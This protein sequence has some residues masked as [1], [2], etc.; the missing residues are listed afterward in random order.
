MLDPVD[1]GELAVV[2]VWSHRSKAPFDFI[3]NGPE[4]TAAFVARVEET[5][6]HDVVSVRPLNSTED[7][8]DGLALTGELYTSNDDL[9]IVRNP[10][11]RRLRAGLENA[12]RATAKRRL[13]SRRPDRSGRRESRGP[14]HPA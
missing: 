11:R 3:T 7:F 6:T 4:A 1:E 10:D 13:N 5:A 2:T 8:I 14:R 9:W 12:D